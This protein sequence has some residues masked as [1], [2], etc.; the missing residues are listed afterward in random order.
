MF[1]KNNKKWEDIKE[2]NNH[3]PVYKKWMQEGDQK[4]LHIR[5][6]D[7]QIEDTALGQHKKSQV[8]QFEASFDTLSHQEQEDWL[9]KLSIMK[10]GD[11]S[12]WIAVI[13][14]FSI[15]LFWEITKAQI[16]IA[17]IQR[18]LKIFTKIQDIFLHYITY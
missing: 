11:S 2:N 6:Q 1:A 13:S 5:S 15:I 12:G 17:L 8:R 7:I 9:N 14:I 3:P 4:L 18:H 16:V 10:K